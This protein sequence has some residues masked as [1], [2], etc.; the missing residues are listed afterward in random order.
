MP[1]ELDLDQQILDDIV[2]EEVAK[3]TS[4]AAPKET[5]RLARLESMVSKLVEGKTKPTQPGGYERERMSL[6]EDEQKICGVVTSLGRGVQLNGYGAA[7]LALK[8]EWGNERINGVI[9]MRTPT[10]RV[11]TQRLDNNKKL[12]GTEINEVVAGE[13]WFEVWGYLE[14]NNR[15]KIGMLAM[16]PASAVSCIVSLRSDMHINPA[17]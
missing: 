17:D 12:V 8:P 13:P 3:K 5:D 7:Q 1:E 2:A 11:G 16:F 6:L 15:E 9:M 4:K 14:S 10:T